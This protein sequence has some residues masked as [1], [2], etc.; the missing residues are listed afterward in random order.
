MW[1]KSHTHIPTREIFPFRKAYFCES[2]SRAHKQIVTLQSRFPAK[3]LLTNFGCSERRRHT[4]WTHHCYLTNQREYVF[5]LLFHK[6]QIFSFGYFS[7]RV[8]KRTHTPTHKQVVLVAIVIIFLLE[9]LFFFW[10][11]RMLLLSVVCVCVFASWWV[12]HVS[13]C[14]PQ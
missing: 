2:F 14:V 10:S 13:C 7:F 3:N 5:R 4:F 8:G 1:T 9:I 12:C 6:R 11:A